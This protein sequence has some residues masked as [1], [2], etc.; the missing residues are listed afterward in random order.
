MRTSFIRLASLLLVSTVCMPA[1]AQDDVVITE[2]MASNDRGL[3]DGNGEFSDWI[4]IYN[5]GTNT[6]N[7]FNWALT[8]VATDLFRWRFPAT[9]INAGQFMVIFASNKDRTTPGAELH[10]NFRL[11]AGGEY[12][13]L[14]R[15]DGSIATEFTQVNGGFPS[16]VPNVSF[17]TAVLSTNDTVLTTNSPARV[18]IPTASTPANWAT[19][20]FNDSSWIQGT[21]GV[22]YGSTNASQI[23]YAAAVLP[24]APVGFWRLNES[25]GTT[26]ANIGSGSA[27]NGTYTSTT[28]GTAGPRSPA[29]GG[30]EANNN[31]PTFNG[32]SS[33]VT[34]NNNILNNRASFT[35]AGWIK[36]TTTASRIG[37]FGQNDCVEFGF[38]TASQLEC[39]TPGGGF[40]RVA[41]THPV[42]TWHHVTAVGNGSNIRIF[43]DGALAG[44]GGTATANYGSSTANFNMGG[45]VFDATGNFFNGQIDEVLVYHRALS[46]S[47][48]QGLYEGG[49]NPVVADVTPFVNTDVGAVMS[50]INATAYIRLPFV[51]PNATNVSL[52][53]LRMRYDDGFAAF[54][55]GTEAL[56]V[57]SPATL[58]YNSAATNV[59]SPLQVDEFRLGTLNL[60]SGTNILAVHGLN[61]TADD[62]DFLIAAHLITTSRAGESPNPVYFTVATPG[63]PNAG[64]VAVPGP[65]ILEPTHSPTLPNDG[66]DIL[67]SA[68]LLPTFNPIAT[69]RLRYRVMFGSE[70]ELEMFDDGMHGDGAAGD[71][72]FAATIPAAAS[73]N[74]QMVRWYFRAT[75]TSGNVSRWPLFTV[76]TETEYLGTMISDPSVVSKLPVVYLFAQPTILQPGPTTSQTGADSQAGSRGVSVFHDGEFYDNIEVAVRGNTT[77]GYNKKSHRFEF[78]PDHAFRHSGPGPRL[79]RTSFVADYPD[80][81]YM[82]QGLC[83]WMGDQIGCPSPFYIPHRL[84]LNGR[85]YQLANHNDVSGEELL[86]RLGY[87]SDGALYNA[88]GRVRSDRASTGG[89]EKRTR[90]WDNDADYTLLTSTTGGIDASVP[91]AARKTNVFELFDIPQVINYLVTA[92]WAHENDDI[93]ANMSMY[94]DN[95][96]DNLWRVLPFD[97][98]LSWGAI[99]YEGSSPAHPTVIEGVVAIYD[100]HKAHPLY[101]SSMNTALSG[102]DGGAAFNQ[103]YDAFF[104]IPETRQMF[105]RRMRS[106][107]DTFV[108]PPGTPVG[109]SP[110]EKRILHLRDLMI[111]E[112]NRDR[113]FWAWPGKGGQCNFDPGIAF[114]NGV[115]G[116]LSNFFLLRRQHFYGK[117]CVTNTAL[118]VGIR[119]NENAGIPL[120]Q[121]GD[122]VVLINN[123]AANGSLGSFNPSSGNQQQEFISITNPQPYAVD[124]SDWQIS[125]AVDFTFAKGT[126]IPIN[127][128]LYVSPNVR[129][130]RARSV[131]PRG[132]QGHFVV[133]PY[134]GQLSAR[135]ETVF[136]HDQYGRLVNTNRYNGTP[137]AVQQ[138]LR[139]TEIMYSPAQPTSGPYNREDFEYIE[140]KN[141]GPSTL[142]LLGVRF[143]NGISFGFTSSGVSSLAPGQRVLVVRNGA[144]FA[145][146]YGTGFPI[147]GQ[148]SGALDNGG[149]RIRLIDTSGEEILDFEYDNDWYPIT[150]GHGFSLVTA[151]ENQDPDLWDNKEGWRASGQL[152]GSPGANDP[153]PAMVAPILINEVLANT[154]T[155]VDFV[156]LYNPTETNVNIGGWFISDDFTNVMKFRIPDGT[157]IAPGGYI[158]FDETQFNADTNLPTSFSFSSRGDEVALAS[159]D[160]AG[161]LTG[162]LHFY[163][164][165]A[166]ENGVSFGP[167]ITSVG[168]EHFVALA[169]VTR[170]AANSAPK[171]GPIVLSEIMYRPPDNG[172]EDNSLDEFVE[173][174]NTSGTTVDLFDP[175]YPTNR[176]KLDKGVD[177]DFPAGTSIPAGGFLLV[178]N[179]NPTNT[180]QLAAFR[181]RYGVSGAV[182]VLGPYEGKLDNS[183]ED[184]ELCKPNPP[185]LDGSVEF[186]LVERVDYSDSPPWPEAADGGGASLQRPG[187]ASYYNDPASWLA[188]L[189]TPGALSPGGT[190]PTITTHPASQNIVAGADLT[191]NVAAS[192]GPLYYQWRHNGG[193]ISGATNSTLFIDNVQPQHR[194]DYDVLVFS[195]AGS[196]TSSNALVNILIGARFFAHPTSIVYNRGS[197]NSA[198]Y[199]HTFSNFT[200]SVQASSSSPLA[201]QWRFNGEDIPGAT[202]TSL[203]VSNATLADAGVYT[204]VVT[205]AVGSIESNPATL[206]IN[207]PPTIYQQ[208]Q[209]ITAVVGDTVNFIVNANG[210]QPLTYQFRRNSV[211]IH[212]PQPL[213]YYTITNVATN[214]AGVYTVVV[215]NVASSG[216]LSAQA[217]LVVL[218]DGDRDRLPDV[219]EDANGFDKTDSEDGDDDTDLDGMKNFEEFIAGTD[220]RDPL[221]YLKVDQLTVGTGANVTFLARSNKT[222]TVE[223]RDDLTASIWQRLTNVTTRATNRIETVID[224]ASRPTRYYRLITPYQ[225]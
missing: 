142:S 165:D 152:G 141:I 191:L 131:A 161:N 89:F 98:N 76:P 66:N 156:E 123:L 43:I 197:T 140:L 193:N 110:I 151:D 11:D 3:R 86:E 154:D 182:A 95:D 80:P 169:A 212:A 9:N 130:F 116:I 62:T 145:S 30:F 148:F 119:T 87:D 36:P 187:D 120:D 195:S 45:A 77:A 25:S 39:W 153:L 91:V 221:S 107:L 8:D 22:G 16:Q 163:E 109:T 137:S 7:L 42:G 102:P 186:V 164:F 218:V 58:A 138:Y 133:G 224:P 173:L 55:N 194:G 181:A 24:T 83:Y 201:Y 23:D 19:T 147:A 32:S 129:A 111:E 1:L 27:L 222:Y 70:V 114:T 225:P 155:G 103:V 34:V 180:V 37:L 188:A 213:H 67:V 15:P 207:I 28:L 85:F 158:V 72:V 190:P 183:G 210:T 117:H 196:A 38:F 64:G 54:I 175:L 52:L 105:L 162:Y 208:P 65:A 135:G 200:F 81:A 56:R 118:P 171:V 51:I 179:F 68:L 157:V 189:P 6:V 125:G 12:L 71:L 149:E 167:H 29:F 21:N 108:L 203:V 202:N 13:A 73:T 223:Y 60:V 211:N 69:V 63:A 2:F 219:Y 47:E 14:V 44:T 35:I 176:W 94:H 178:V 144:A 185:E 206:T 177:F 124:I 112:A 204:V 121:P 61:R 84:Q 99:F 100:N 150:D 134:R 18:L 78:N 4:E 96:G 209:P 170:G 122:A 205:D 40:V 93:W 50:N 174:R 159:A 136:L 214:Q 106:M 26:A 113:A 146:R 192:P 128:V 90:R 10:T 216:I 132:G 184:I 217:Q 79:R 49:L 41:Y 20:S 46:D 74:G 168:E 97:M 57:N 101:G 53:T 31:A 17:G 88:A 33:F 59:H 127:S 5:A 139:I 220:P 172:A 198:T 75:D 104:Q 166:S 115:Q 143:T 199:G 92:R 82:R 215:R 126:V 48:I 160:A